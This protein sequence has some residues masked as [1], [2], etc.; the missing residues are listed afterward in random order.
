[1]N[2]ILPILNTKM[3]ALNKDYDNFQQ[4]SFHFLTEKC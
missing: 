1:M 2:K 3:I 4:N